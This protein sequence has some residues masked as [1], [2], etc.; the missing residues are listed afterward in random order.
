MAKK[1]KQIPVKVSRAEAQ[2]KDFFDMISPATMKFNADHFI[3]GDTYRSVW[4]VREYPPQTSDQAILCHL[5]DKENVTLHIYSRYVDN[6]EQRKIF[7]NAT[8][9]NRMLSTSDDVQEAVTAEGNMEDVV[10]LLSELR[11]N[12][13]PLLHCAV[14]IE[15]SAT[16]LDKLKEIQTEVNME[17]TRERITVDRLTLR[18]QE[19]FKACMPCGYNAFASLFERVL[20]ASAVA[21][22]YPFNYSGKTDPNGFYIGKDRYGTNIL[23]DFDCRSDDKTN[24]NILILGNSGQ[25]KS[26]LL[27]L[28]LVAG[29]GVQQLAH[30]LGLL[31]HIL[32]GLRRVVLQLLGE[33]GQRLFQAISLVLNGLEPILH[34]GNVVLQLFHVR[35]LIPQ[36]IALLEQ[37]LAIGRLAHP[38]LEAVRLHIHLHELPQGIQ[39]HIISLHRSEKHF[40][41]AL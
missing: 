29:E 20:P 30:R 35:L 14:F 13:E 41:F 1:K 31:L 9:K 6:V 5:G 34:D 12:K 27:K 25:G 40:G 33:G 7:Q 22:L 10:T 37:L 36:E 17:L 24:S 16:S 18:Q 21:N 23:V 19:G 28:L 15:L 3:C 2:V 38:G 8:R 4:A 32:R 11:K 26:Y 39:L